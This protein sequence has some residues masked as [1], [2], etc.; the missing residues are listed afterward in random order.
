ME[1]IGI[2]SCSNQTSNI[3]LPAILSTEHTFTIYPH[4]TSFTV[5]L[6][7]LWINAMHLLNYGFSDVP[8]F[9]Y[10]RTF[11]Q[12]ASPYFT[13][14][15]PQIS[16]DREIYQVSYIYAYHSDLLGTEKELRQVTVFK[17]EGDSSCSSVRVGYMILQRHSNIQLDRIDVKT[18]TL[19]KGERFEIRTMQSYSYWH[20]FI[21]VVNAVSK[22]FCSL[23]STGSLEHLISLSLSQPSTKRLEIVADAFT[24][25][26]LPTNSEHSCLNVLYIEGFIIIMTHYN[27]IF[28]IT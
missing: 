21:Q 19:L 28:Y 26:D 20:L 1:Q 9:V 4:C 27:V 16:S 25:Q 5:W 3:T 13:T 10:N 12:A 14:S 24:D 17:L 15:I 2:I 23:Y 22:N 6:S 11:R 7:F 8:N 18:V